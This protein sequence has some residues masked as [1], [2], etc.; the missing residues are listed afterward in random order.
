MIASTEIAMPA[1]HGSDDD[2]LFQ[3]Q[4]PVEL[5]SSD[6]ANTFKERIITRI[7]NGRTRH[8]MCQAPTVSAS[9]QAEFLRAFKLYY[10]PF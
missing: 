6:S 2:F 7:Q 9:W 4:H 1:F 3:L 5:P 8:M 10:W